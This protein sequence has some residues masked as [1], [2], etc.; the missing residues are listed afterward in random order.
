MYKNITRALAGTIVIREIGNCRTFFK[1]SKV[2]KIKKNRVITKRVCVNVLSCGSLT[3]VQ[4]KLM[5]GSEI[6]GDL[7]VG[8]AFVS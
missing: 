1:A 2:D 7:I 3:F 4:L 5:L 6:H 8:S